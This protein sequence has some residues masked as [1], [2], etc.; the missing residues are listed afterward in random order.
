MVHESFFPQVN[1]YR[2][3]SK[4]I[5]IPEGQA[6]TRKYELEHFLVNNTVELAD[7]EKDV[8]IGE[9]LL[10]AFSHSI[11]SDDKPDETTLYNIKNLYTEL[12]VKDWNEL[13]QVAELC[14]ICISNNHYT[15]S[16]YAGSSECSDKKT[17]ISVS[18][19]AEQ[20][21]NALRRAL[22]VSRAL[23]PFAVK[24]T[25]PMP[26]TYP[27][28]LTPYV[29][30]AILKLGGKP[31]ADFV[32]DKDMVVKQFLVPSAI[33]QFFSFEFSGRYSTHESDYA[34]YMI[35]AVEMNNRPSYLDPANVVVANRGNKFLVSFAIAD[36]GNYFLAF[37][38]ND[39]EP[40]DP[41]VFKIDHYD[42][43]QKIY[44]NIRLSAFLND[45]TQDQVER[46]SR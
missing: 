6:K 33:R 3:D 22:D 1:A 34:T 31:K 45:L 26:G 39:P 11:L 13:I 5:L 17:N 36:G 19:V 15:Y 37:D 7:T 2:K 23:N 10:E 21:G 16:P 20:I 14:T 18:A 32:S 12:G 44:S 9:K 25:N 35:W 28:Q 4:I 8:K 40:S 41:A 27:G 46:R 38:L 42:P 30:A 29:T 24:Q 43:E